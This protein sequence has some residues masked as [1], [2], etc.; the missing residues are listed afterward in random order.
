[1]KWDSEVK[2]VMKQ[3][4]LTCKR[5]NSLVNIAK[6]KKDPVYQLDQII[7]VNEFEPCSFTAIPDGTQIYTF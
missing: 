6:S 2:R 3:K 4:N 7:F 1:M 5:Y